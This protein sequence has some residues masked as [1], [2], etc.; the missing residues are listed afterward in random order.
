MP[1]RLRSHRVSMPRALT[2]MSWYTTLP[3]MTQP[4][5]SRFMRL[6]LRRNVDLPQPNGPMRAV[7][8]LLSNERLV[9]FRARLPE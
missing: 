7:T 2:L 9:S 8:D 5:I 1:T 6:M 3:P 4:G